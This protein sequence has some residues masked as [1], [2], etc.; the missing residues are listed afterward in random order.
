[1]T[2]MKMKPYSWA[3]KVIRFKHAFQHKKF[4]KP[5]DSSSLVTLGSK[6]PTNMARPVSRRCLAD[7]NPITG[8]LQSTS[9]R[10][11]SLSPAHQNCSAKPPI[12]QGNISQWLHCDLNTIQVA[13]IEVPDGSFC[14][15]L[16]IKV[17]LPSAIG[18]A[19]V[20]GSMGSSLKLLRCLT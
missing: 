5:R 7:L 2:P 6:L 15:L 19:T 12:M 8:S 10:T 9:A 3:S 1:M 20:L 13:S 4:S 14:S 17:H 11:L 18:T 16:A